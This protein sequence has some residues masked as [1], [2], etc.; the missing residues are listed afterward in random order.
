MVAPNRELA[1]KPLIISST[2]IFPSQNNILPT[3]DIFNNIGMDHLKGR[4]SNDNNK[5]R[6]RKLSFSS[7]SSRDNSMLLVTFSRPYHERMEQYNNMDVDDHNNAPSKLSYEASQEKKIC[8]RVVAE[9]RKDMLPSQGNL[10]NDNHSQYVYEMNPNSTFTQGSTVQNDESTF[11]NISIPYDPDVSAD[12]K[13]WGGNFH[14]VSLHSL[15]EYLASDIKNI[16]DS[17]KFMT[18]YITNK[19]IDSL[20]ANNLKD[21]EGIGVSQIRYSLVVILELNGVSEVQYKNVMMID[22]GKYQ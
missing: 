5:V 8:L 19:K 7:N 22:D 21:F 13:I 17:L 1:N 20:K 16:K 4:T 2:N 12:L 6:G 18:K 10:T 3:V 9:N 11:F 14:L 15:I